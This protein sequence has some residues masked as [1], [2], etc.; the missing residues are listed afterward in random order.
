MAYS[1]GYGHNIGI[2]GYFLSTAQKNTR[3]KTEHNGLSPIGNW[4]MLNGSSRLRSVIDYS[5]LT[6]SYI[7]QDTFMKYAQNSK[8][9]VSL[10]VDKPDITLWSVQYLDIT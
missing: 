1:S 9:C 4:F 6:G 8:I 3:Q 2:T 7:Y 10:S 5:T